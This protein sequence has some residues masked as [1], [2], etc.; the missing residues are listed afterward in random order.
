VPSAAYRRYYKVLEQQAAMLDELVLVILD[1]LE[2]TLLSSFMHVGLNSIY[3]CFL[4][5]VMCRREAIYD[6]E[7]L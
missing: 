4:Q 3:L 6:R 7:G 2:Q 5:G 1:Y